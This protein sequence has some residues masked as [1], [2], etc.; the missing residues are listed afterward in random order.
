MITCQDCGKRVYRYSSAKFCFDCVEK[1][2]RE[3][4]KIRRMRKLK[5]FKEECLF[6]QNKMEEIHHAD[7][8]KDNNNSNNLIPLCRK[9]HRKIHSLIIKPILKVVK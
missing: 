2:Q 9:C 4:E 8:N 6:C 1:H 3:G 7:M 5:G